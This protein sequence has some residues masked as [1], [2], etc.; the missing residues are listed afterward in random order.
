[1]N[2]P[3]FRDKVK[4]WDLPGELKRG[5]TRLARIK[6]AMNALEEEARQ[7]VPEKQQDT[8]TETR[9]EQALATQP[10]SSRTTR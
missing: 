2:G 10:S 6:E 5:E 4:G 9:R 3:V 1:M 7:E 8:E